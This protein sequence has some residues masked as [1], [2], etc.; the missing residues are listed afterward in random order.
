MSLIFMDSEFTG[1]HRD[2]TLISLGLISDN[3]KSF[4]AE[5][6]DYDKSQ[7]DPWIQEN[8]LAHLKFPNGQFT[9]IAHRNDGELDL[10]GVE[11]RLPKELVREQLRTWLSQFGDIQLVSDVCHYDMV[12]FIDIFGGAFDLPWNVNAACHD[13]NQD[14]ARYCGIS[15]KAAFDLSREEF[16]ADRDKT[17]DGDKHNALYDAKVIRE[18]YHI[19]NGA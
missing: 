2:T 16:I 13:A 7:C 18:I 15:E 1:L 12:L 10:N 11:M 6:T 14:I 19:T 17:I 8:V 9:R 5:F 3:G 4:Y